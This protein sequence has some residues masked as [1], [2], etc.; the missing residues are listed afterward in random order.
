MCEILATKYLAF[1]ATLP[2]PIFSTVGAES[3]Q[4]CLFRTRTSWLGACNHQSET[5]AIF[6]AVLGPTRHVEVQSRYF[7]H[8]W[9]QFQ[10]CKT[11]NIIFFQI[12]LNFNPSLHMR[13]SFFPPWYFSET[14]NSQNWFRFW[15]DQKERCFRVKLFALNMCLI[16]NQHTTYWIRCVL[17]FNV[18]VYLCFYVYVFVPVY[19]CISPFKFPHLSARCDSSANSSDTSILTESTPNSSTV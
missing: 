6:E 3:A 13:Y 8:N 11:L 7:G 17:Y 12:G 14:S 5:S 18:F 4:F 2:S 15:S 16:V 10:F 19:L 9:N 1:F